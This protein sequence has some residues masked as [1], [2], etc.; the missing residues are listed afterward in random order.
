MVSCLLLSL[1]EH[2]KADDAMKHFSQ[3]RTTDGKALN[4]PSQIRYVN[5]W[6]ELLKEARRVSEETLKS[7]RK[8][9]QF[10][11]PMPR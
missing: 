4:Q 2:T 1:G 9:L 3:K 5:Y 6:A 11:T 8:T 10:T 7:P